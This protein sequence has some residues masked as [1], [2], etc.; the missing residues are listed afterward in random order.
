MPDLNQSLYIAA[1]D[2]LKKHDVPEYLADAAS[3][4]VAT[5]EAGKPNLGRTEI[6][7]EICYEI[8]IIVTRNILPTEDED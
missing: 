1:Y 7:R 4:I 2:G 3:R 5:D 6:D 8:A